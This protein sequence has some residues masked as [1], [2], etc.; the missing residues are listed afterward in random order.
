MDSYRYGFQNQEKDDEIKGAGNSV[1]F[2][3]RMY[4]ARVGRWLSVDAL[5]KKYPEN[6]TYVFC[7]N[8]PI[9]FV[10]PDGRENIPALL[11]ALNNMANQG[12][13]SDYS[14]PWY[15]SKEGGWTFKQGV[16]PTRIV[17]YESCWISYM[18][19]A[20]ATTLKTLKTGFSTNG[21]GFNGR[22]SESGG[23]NWFKKGNESNGRLF[24][25]DITKGE[26][27][28]IVFMGESAGMEGHA[29]MLASE[30]TKESIEFEGKII[31]LYKFTA[32][33]TSS[34]SDPMNFGIKEFVFQ[35]NKDGSF[36]QFGGSGYKLRGIGQMTDV[37]SSIEERNKVK[38]L[39]NEHNYNA[40]LDEGSGSDGETF[41]EN[42]E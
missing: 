33:S 2:E 40:T 10:D 20:S 7:S 42:Q 28:D 9:F 1:N 39:V 16:I 29:V 22:S 25:T 4:D 36:V 18:N 17:C 8:N 30:I 37:I 41:D 6:S 19:G 11:W 32:L 14:N 13:T 23:E 21:L 5:E 15:G 27:G 24:L 31:E 12:I 3:F 35:K 34:N 38:E 26:L